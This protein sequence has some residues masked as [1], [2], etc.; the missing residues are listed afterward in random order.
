MSVS[1]YCSPTHLKIIIGDADRG[2]VSISDFEEYLLPAGAMINGIITDEDVMIGFLKNI[3]A[4]R[5]LL[6]QKTHIVI[7]NNNIKAKIL[8]LPP[9]N[10]SQMLGLVM[11]DV[12]H[13]EGTNLD[14]VVID[15][16]IIDPVAGEGGV[17]VLSVAVDKNLLYSYRNV[18]VSAGFDPVNINIGLNTMIKL[19]GLMPQLK[20]G[21]CILAGLDD[22]RLMLALFEEGTYILSNKYRIMAEIGT[23]EWYQEIGGDIHSVMQF[24]TGQKPDA[25]VSAAYFAGTAGDQ[26]TGLASSL[27]Y[28]GIKIQDLNLADISHL[29]GSAAEKKDMFL[30]GKYIFNIGTL[31]RR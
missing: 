27:S 30:P 17:K 31:L 8:A 7:D 12:E 10:E 14:D 9:V 28:L 11:R 5:S 16:A 6:N 25:Q 13:F 15:Y 29:K 3:V 22:Q 4:S 23:P 20:T 24:Q 26:T 18:I 1:L 21:N 19:A 2:G